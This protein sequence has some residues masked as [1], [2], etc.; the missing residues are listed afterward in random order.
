MLT[1]IDIKDAA[2]LPAEDLLDLDNL[3]ADRHPA[4]TEHC[5]LL[6]PRKFGG[7]AAGVSRR[8]SPCFLVVLTSR[9]LASAV[10]V[11]VAA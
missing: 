8:G 4:D 7:N 10:A 3:T 1:C 2:R 11:T 5:K 6:Q 9:R